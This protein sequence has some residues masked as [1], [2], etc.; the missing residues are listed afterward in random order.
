MIACRICYSLGSPRRG[1]IVVFRAPAQAASR[2]SGAGTFVKRLIGLP[3]ER[4]HEDGAGFISVDGRRLREPYVT[5]VARAADTDYLNRT[6]RVP[7]GEYFMLGDNRGDS[8][9]SRAWG[10]VARGALI[11]PVITTYWPPSRISFP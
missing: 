7:N 11:G 6:W 8:C 5:A 1:Q 3:N 4:V 10:P 2:C 9:D